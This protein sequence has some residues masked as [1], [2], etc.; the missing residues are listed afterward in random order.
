[1]SGSYHK[2]RDSKMQQSVRCGGTVSIFFLSREGKEEPFPTQKTILSVGLD[3]I[4]VPEYESRNG[5]ARISCTGRT[6]TPFLYSYP[7]LSDGQQVSKEVPRLYKNNCD[8]VFEEPLTGPFIQIS[9]KQR[10]V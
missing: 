7:R 9:T 6:G 3:N 10:S 2:E 8:S 4:V 1:M 5:L